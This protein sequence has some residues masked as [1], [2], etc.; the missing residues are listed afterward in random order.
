MTFLIGSANRDERRFQDA[1]RFN[2][3]RPAVKHFTFGYGIHY[4]LGAALARIEGRIALEELL[5]RFP[6]WEVDVEQ[7]RLTSASVVR[8]WDTL[9]ALIL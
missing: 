7:A 5:K 2:I 4:C 6:H 3:H 8:G 1:D 9:P